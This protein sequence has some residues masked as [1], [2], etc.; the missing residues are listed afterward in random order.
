MNQNITLE[1]VLELAKQ[2]SA[3]DKIRLVNEITPSI[4]QNSDFLKQV[5]KQKRIAEGSY[6]IDDFN[7]E[8]QEAINNVETKQ[9]LTICQDKND[10]YN[11]LDI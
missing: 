7:E 5:E 1:L 8:T 10:L 2:L 4:N 11:E 9:N 3:V 6:T